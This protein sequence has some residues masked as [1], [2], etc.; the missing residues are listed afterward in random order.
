MAPAPPEDLQCAANGYC[1]APPG[2]AP[3][4]PAGGDGELRWL[5]RC[6]AA[7]GKGFAIGAGL[8][9]GLAL[10]SVLVRIRSR[11]SPRSRKAGAMTNEEAVVLAVKETVRYGLFLGTFAGSYVSVDEYIAA[12][13]GRKRSV[14]GTITVEIVPN[15]TNWAVLSSTADLLAAETMCELLLR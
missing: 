4:A 9:G 14:H 2:K 10:F 6:L 12:V 15:F 11:R 13:W 3:V 7:A 8:K 1:A 5:R